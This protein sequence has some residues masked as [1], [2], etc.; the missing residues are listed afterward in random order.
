MDIDNFTELSRRLDTTG[1]DF[2]AFRSQPLDESVLRCLRYMHDVELHT[3][4]YLRDLLVTS[5]HRDPEI[6]AFLTM[7]NMEE[8][9]HGEAIG[10]VLAAHG[11]AA[12]RERL[13]PMRQRLQWKDRVAPILHSLGSSIVGES[14]IS[15]HMTWGAVNEWTTQVA[16]SR[17]IV[18]AQ[19]PVLTDLLKRIM[20]QEG[21]HI[22]FYASQADQ[23][24]EGNRRA[25]WMTRNALKRLWAPVGTTVMPA[26]EVGHMTRFLFDGTEGLAAAKRIDAKVDQLP[27]LH[28]LDLLQ[29]E[30]RRIATAVV[31]D[32]HEAQVNRRAAPATGTSQG[33]P[34]DR[35][36]GAEGHADAA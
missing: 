25:Q 22:D 27:G 29:R 7:W 28:G 13:V 24:L 36:D 35:T 8:Y 21:R 17:L 32:L 19:H 26:S 33:H 4:C 9:W 23:R 3:V 34:H 18:K 16:Y 31:F 10:N 2:D 12:K 15:M 6:T 5:A 11:E 1:I 30:V 20:K 14:F